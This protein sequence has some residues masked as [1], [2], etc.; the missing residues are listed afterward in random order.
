MET[1]TPRLRKSAKT[2]YNSMPIPSAGIET[3]TLEERA[4]LLEGQDAQFPGEGQIHSLTSRPQAK[5]EPALAR[6]VTFG[7]S[8]L[9]TVKT[10]LRC[11][12]SNYLLPFV[13]LGIIA[14][15]QRWD[16][17]LVFVLNFLAILPLASLLSF[18]TEELAK[19]VGQLVGGLINATFG[20]AIEMIVRKR[21]PFLPFEPAPDMLGIFSSRWV[22]LQLVEGKLTLSNRVWLEASSLG[23]F[24]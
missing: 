2:D 17:T 24:W 8:V 19:S 12:Y 4:I 9:G 23:A 18:A 20:N 6:P 1:P 7:E 14:G 11:S 22:S 21:H 16:D 10:T 3:P 5:Y 15:R 13:L